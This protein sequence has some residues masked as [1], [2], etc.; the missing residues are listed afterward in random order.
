MKFTSIRSI[1][2][3]TL[4]Q[5]NIPL[6]YY[7]QYIKLASDCLRELRFSHL[8]VVETRRL[9]VNSY[10]AVDL[11]CN[12]ADIVQVGIPV[13]QFVRPLHQQSGINRLANIDSVGAKIPYGA[14]ASG[15]VDVVTG[16]A[17]MYNDNDEAIGRF[18]GF[19][20]G[21]LADTY[22]FLPERNQIQLNESVGA[23]EI[24]LVYVS[25]GSDCDA[26][27]KVDVLAQDCIEKYIKWQHSA[28]SDNPYSP[29]GKSYTL[30]L[31]ILRA[32]KSGITLDDIKRAFY[33]SVKPTI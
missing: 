20:D 6:H 4:L 3:S 14:V 15:D 2:K 29:E 5:R 1:A 25:D 22:K 27:T 8:R 31:R 33:S 9:P 19:H 30:A 13:G 21:L 10:K 16:G 7:L 28:N 17:I 24:I 23:T 18:F 11:P 26:A 32:R 12:T